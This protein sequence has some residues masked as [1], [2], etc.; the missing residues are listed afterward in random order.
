MCD[1]RRRR[2]VGL[3]DIRAGRD[4]EKDSRGTLYPRSSARQCACSASSA[5]SG[6]PVAELHERHDLLT[7]AV[8]R[9]ADHDRVEH[10]L[11]RADRGLDLFGED[12]LAA[13]VDAARTATEQHD[14][15]GV[16]D[17]RRS[18]PARPIA[19]RPRRSGRSPRSSLRPSSTRAGCGRAARTALPSP[20]RVRASR[21]SRDRGPRCGRRWRT[22]AGRW[23]CS[24]RFRSRTRRSP[25]RRSCR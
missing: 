11:V 14:A 7:E 10:V 19:L 1:R 3:A 5:S 25:T 8:V 21:A 4:T 16:V 17:R 15:P 22:R 9:H 24:R 18:R 12:L 20:N 6:A 23:W 2:V 13:G